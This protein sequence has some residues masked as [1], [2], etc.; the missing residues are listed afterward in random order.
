[1]ILLARSEKFELPTP[2]FEVWCSIQLSYER[3]AAACGG[4]GPRRIYAI[5]SLVPWRGDEGW[6]CAVAFSAGK[7]RLAVSFPPA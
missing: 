2:K 6:I 3:L 4:G 5:G 7:P 1:M